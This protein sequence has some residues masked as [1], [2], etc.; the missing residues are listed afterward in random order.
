MLTAS[1]L[2]DARACQRRHKHKYIDGY[3]P[4]DD[5]APLRFGTLFHA[6]LASWWG[7]APEFRLEFALAETLE[8]SDPY[9]AAMARALIVGYDAR[10]SDDRYAV[11]AVEREFRVPLVNPETGAKSRTWDLGGKLDAIARE[12]SGR[13]L[14]VEHKTTSSEIAPGSDYWK[15][16]R[17]DGQVSIYFEGA[18]ASG[19][20]V[21]ACLYD[22]I[23][24]PGQRPLKATPEDKRQYKKDGTPYATTRLTDETPEQYEARLMEAIA[25]DPSRHFARGEVVRLDREMDEAM[26]DAW[27]I[28]QQLRAAEVADRFPRN[29]DAC[30]QYGR[31]CAFFGVCTGEQS[32]DDPLLFKRVENVHPELS[33]VTNLTAEREG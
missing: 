31:T 4:L 23:R 7:H 29:V 6:A 16:L 27:T 17:L 24:K 30:V 11:L 33:Q 12:T 20:D 2:R 10:W 15:M 5:A 14:L 3:R 28:A 8:A 9:E 25:A 13:V 26:F 18:R 32:L 22:V 19:Y 1:R 21:A